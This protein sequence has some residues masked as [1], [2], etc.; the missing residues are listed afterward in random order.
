MME[1]FCLLNVPRSIFCLG[2]LFCNSAL[3]D[4]EFSCIIFLQLHV[5][6]KLSKNIKFK[7]SNYLF[8]R[9]TEVPM[10]QIFKSTQ[11]KMVS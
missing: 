2:I 11:L 8:D 3:W 10:S 7:Y 6:L 5:S 4:M 1:I 9:N